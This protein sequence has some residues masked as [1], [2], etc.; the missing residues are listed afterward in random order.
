MPEF[1]RPVALDTRGE[2]ART[3]AV[4]A[5]EGERAA[6]ARRFGLVA[7]DRLSAE[8]ALRRAGR[9]VTAT[10]RIAA[11]VTQSC[12]A[13]GAPVHQEID[14]LF[15]IAFR[16]PPDDSRPDEEIELAEGELDTVFYEGG[17]IDLGE[18]RG[19]GSSASASVSAAASP[20]SIAPPS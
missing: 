6:L 7:I 10:G 8:A 3:I 20:R 2:A 14:A 16:P 5:D 1:S 12:V 15:E 18:A 9:A 4:E 19:Q 13:S 11:A 17:A